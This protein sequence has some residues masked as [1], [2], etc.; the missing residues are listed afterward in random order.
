MSSDLAI[1]VKNVS[2]T[3]RIAHEKRMRLKDYFLRPFSK[4]KF[5]R[6]DALKDIS[7]DIKKG[8]FVGIIGRNGSGKSTLLKILAGVYIADEGEVQISGKLVPFLELGVGFNPELTGRENVYLNGT[9][10]GMTNKEIKHKYH[11]IVDFS[12]LSEFMDTQLKHYSSGMQVRLAFAIA[13][14]AKGDIYLLDEVLAVGDAGF[15]AKSQAEILKLIKNGKTIIFVSHDHNVVQK[16]SD[17]VIWLNKSKVA[18]IAD[19]P[20]TIMNV[21]KK[22]LQIFSDVEEGEYIKKGDNLQL[23]LL[24]QDANGNQ[25]KV[26]EK[27]DQFFLRISYAYTGVNDISNLNVGFAILN[28]LGVTI[29]GTNTFAQKIKLSQ[30]SSEIVFEI[31]N[32][33]LLAG[34]YFIQLG[35]EFKP[36]ISCVEES[37]K[38]EFTVLST[39]NASGITFFDVKVS[40]MNEK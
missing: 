23:D 7:F 6:F 24:M 26:F 28:D 19:T 39:E 32:L 3:F 14:Q 1:S 16:L 38:Y 34:N 17:R 18:E 22:Y 4:V 31:P 40:I 5:S 29:F 37:Q 20:K 15:Q 8:E 36:G 10:L 25:T 13:I 33:N 2:K 11:E 27:N 30:P 12:E 35:A 9:I 21:I